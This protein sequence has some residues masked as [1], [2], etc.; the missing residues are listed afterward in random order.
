MTAEDT[1]QIQALGFNITAGSLPLEDFLN[2]TFPGLNVL[3]YVKDINDLLQPLTQSTIIKELAFFEN[4]P[5]MLIVQYFSED[6][7]DETGLGL[8]RTFIKS[9]NEFIV[10]HDFFRL[11]SAKRRQGIAKQLLGFSLQQ[12]LSSGVDKIK[13][14]AELENGGYVWAKTEFTATD[15]TEV[16]T[17]L[18]NAEK[19]ISSQQFKFVK[20]VYDNYYD[21]NP[22]GRNFPMIKWSELPE[23]EE[24]L[25]G[26]KWQGEID[27][28]NKELLAKFKHYVA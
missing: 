8:S 25:N 18:D 2:S 11:P 16:K 28:N 9:K 15:Q 21:K 17:I 23:M 3:Q 13:L 7:D 1:A 14:R 12:Y 5:P 27:L 6:S 22:N 19:T 10:E 20:R 4:A 24:I 26:S